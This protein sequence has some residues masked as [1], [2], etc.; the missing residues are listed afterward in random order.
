MTLEPLRYDP[1]LE[2]PAPDEGETIASLTETMRSIS[3]TTFADS[4]HGLRSVHAKSHALLQGELRVLDGLPETLAQG[5]FA[6]PATYPV[7]MRFS[8]NPGDLLDDSVS[9][10]RGLAI[11][12][13]GVEGERL[14]G[15]AGAVTQDFVMANAPAFAA[16]TPKAFVGNLRLLAKTPDAAQGL[17][18][19]LSFVLRG[20]EAAIESVGLKS[21]AVL[22]MGGQPLTHVLGETF[23]TQVPSLYGPYVAKL[24]VAP[25][26]ANLAALTGAKVDVSGKPDGLRE[27]A[28]EAVSAQGG[29]W[30]VR[31]QLCTNR[32]TMPI[33]DASV[34]WPEDES[35][36]VAVARITVRPQ[37]AW[38]EARSAAF[39]D[40][41]AF[42]PWHGLAAHRPLGGVNRARKPAY[43][44]S[45]DLRGARNGC[46]MHEPRALEPLEA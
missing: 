36:Y 21:A 4:G 10:P 19:A 37:P 41:L 15:S 28:T 27:A 12:I 11:K 34:A 13:V 31:V 43:E 17:K 16:A 33:E 18:K 30:E 32:E 38:S 44:M 39:D 22:S 8:T 46:P 35:P 42:S 29:E 25:T 9:A 7:A 3:E 6:R 2:Q 40:G 14:E 20:T 23:Y 45:A 1:S 24:S 5:V 26:S